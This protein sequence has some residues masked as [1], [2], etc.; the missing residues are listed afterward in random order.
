MKYSNLFDYSDDDDEEE[1]EEE[2]EGDD[3][4]WQYK[5]AYVFHTECTFRE[6]FI[7]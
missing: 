4:D 5:I 1:E 6:V 7:V 3:D 2:E